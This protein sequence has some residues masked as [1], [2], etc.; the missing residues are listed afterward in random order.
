M[1]SSETK[2]ATITNCWYHCGFLDNYNQKDDDDLKINLNKMQ[3]KLKDIDKFA[4]QSFSSEN[5]KTM[6]A[7]EFT[8]DDRECIESLTD[9][10]ILLIVRKTET[11]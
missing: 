7:E 2:Q 1:G 5:S 11:S 9:A 8:I 4:F 3:I 6:T 10:E